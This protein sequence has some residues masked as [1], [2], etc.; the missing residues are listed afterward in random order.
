MGKSDTQL[1]S[2]LS[3]PMPAGLYHVGMSQLYT[4]E[5]VY[6]WATKD[7][8]SKIYLEKIKHPENIPVGNWILLILGFLN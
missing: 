5:Y 1:H 6:G 2:N 4:Y 3:L 8:K 7:K